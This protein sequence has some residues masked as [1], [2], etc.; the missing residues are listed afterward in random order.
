MYSHTRSRSI[1]NKCEDIGLDVDLICN[2]EIVIEDIPDE[3]PNS[4]IDLLRC[5]AI[6]TDVLQRAV[7]QSRPNLFANQILNLATC[8]N[9]FYRDCKIIENGEVN[10]LYLQ[11]SQLAS[12]LLKSG[13]EGLGITPL[14]RM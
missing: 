10:E 12:Q 5:M 9:G 6:Q 4:L 13:M 8:F 3:L 2:K 14:E 11:I 1:A 7:E